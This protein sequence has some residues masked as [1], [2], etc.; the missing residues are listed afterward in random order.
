MPATSTPSE[1]TVGT[2]SPK[3]NRGL[4]ERW[5]SFRFPT[6]LSRRERKVVRQMT[7]QIP[8]PWMDTDR[9]AST[10][11]S[12]IIQLV[13]D[14]WL[15][16]QEKNYSSLYYGSQ[17]FMAPSLEENYVSLPYWPGLEMRPTI[18]PTELYGKW[19]VSRTCR[20]FKSQCGSSGSFLHTL[21]PA[22]SQGE[23]ALSVWVR[24]WTESEQGKQGAVLKYTQDGYDHNNAY[25]CKP[26]KFGTHLLLY[27]NLAYSN[28]HSH[29]KKANGRTIYHKSKNR[30]ILAWEIQAF[31][32]SCHDL[33]LTYSYL[34]D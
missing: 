9:C 32:S 15:I 6:Q 27:H 18:Q 7:F 34:V 1:D 26:L 2:F 12:F 24:E 8:H 31:S 33:F 23:I 30:G 3:V 14:Q 19:C 28:W 10:F 5:Q 16:L 22:I 17:I 25:C 20:S 4:W 21:W 29:F 13:S 11:H